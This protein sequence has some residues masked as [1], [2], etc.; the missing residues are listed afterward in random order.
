[1]TK[2]IVPLPLLHLFLLVSTTITFTGTA[3]ASSSAAYP[4]VP[5]DC[6][7]STAGDEKLVPIRREVYG[8]GNIFDISHRYTANM[9]SWG[10]NDGLGQFLWLPVSMKNGNQ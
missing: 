5:T 2:T 4:S 3:T 8:G 6:T 7:L 9:P 10:S 1:M